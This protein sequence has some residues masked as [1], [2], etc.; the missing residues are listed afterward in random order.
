[1]KKDIR[2][3]E[4]LLHISE[5]KLHEAEIA[6]KKLEEEQI[7]LK[8]LV[9]YYE[10]RLRISAN[11]QFGKSSEQTEGDHAQMRLFD[12][13]E[14][15]ADHKKDEPKIE[16]ITYVRCKR[17]AKKST[18]NFDLL[19][20]ERIEHTIAEEELIC[21]VCCGKLHLIGFD[22][23]RE[24]VIVP[25]TVKVVVHARGIYGCRKCDNENI[26]VPIIKAPMPQPVIKGS[27]ASSSAI[28]HVMVQKY[29]QGV[30]LYRQEQAF[31]NDSLLLSR[32]TMANWLIRATTDWL[33]PIYEE[34]RQRMLQEEILHAD[35]TELQVL[36]EPGRASRSTSYMWLYR[37]GKAAHIQAVLYEYT[38]TRSSAH[39]IRFLKNF[40]GYLHTDGYA[41]YGKLGP[42][43]HRCGCWA[44]LRRK[45]NEAVTA[46]PKELQ[47]TCPSQ[48]GLS[49]CNKLF[50]L[51]QEYTHLTPEERLKKRLEHSR[52]IM[53]AFFTWAASTA[54]LPK[55]ALGKALTY[56]FTQKTTLEA[57]LLDGRIEIS[58]NRAERSI[59][60]FV[61]GRKN[62]LFS[63]SPKGAATSAVI[64][65]IIESAKENMLNP[66]EYLK[67]LFDTMPNINP[68]EYNTLLP[69]SD[70][71][72]DN[73]RI[74]DKTDHTS[75][76]S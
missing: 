64:Y 55:S 50:E 70:H 10:E 66:F 36:R 46:A 17:G 12:E 59:K 60:P 43:I 25:A 24:L 32:Q 57:Y 65:S 1:M 14:N 42:H 26:V 71:L 34:M 69:W 56:S 33:S 19:P 51:E 4:E 44:H 62:W 31:L 47:V 54:A 30:P 76:T 18:D 23:R 20:Q 5:E 3:V 61:I 2:N 7:K 41:G 72:P 8:A 29:L 27:P 48:T 67:Y 28:A 35:E 63:C 21:D 6:C 68:E 13:A 58:N 11:K 53:D 45:F 37:T 52:P 38:P 75:S 16:E 39:P 15:E 9:A 73:C 49:Y 74:A 22:E 40:R